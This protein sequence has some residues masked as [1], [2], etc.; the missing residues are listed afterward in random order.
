MKERRS[1][2]IIHSHGNT[3]AEG[4]TARQALSRASV[5]LG[6]RDVRAVIDVRCL[7][8]RH[9]VLGG[10]PGDG[11]FAAFVLPAAQPEVRL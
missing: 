9:P 8:V 4:R 1:F 11:P 3:F 6:F 5:P 2:C 10:F 7:T